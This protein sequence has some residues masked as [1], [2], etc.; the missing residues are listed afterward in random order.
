MVAKPLSD[1]LMFAIDLM[2]IAKSNVS[3][4]GPWTFSILFPVI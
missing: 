4:I 1:H 3:E 2:I